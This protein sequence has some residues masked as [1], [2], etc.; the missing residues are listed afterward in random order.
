M[1]QM[2]ESNLK[3]AFAGESQAHMKYLNFAEKARADGLANVARLFEAAALSEQ[4][5]ASRHLSALAG[6][7]TTSE[8][9]AAAGGGE[10]F[11]IE[12]MYP[13]YVAVADSQSEAGAKKTMS[14]A[15]EAE[16]VHQRLFRAAKATVDD[17]KDADIPAIHVCLH[18]G[19]TMEGD[20]PDRCPVCG[21]PKSQFQAF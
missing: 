17:G 12:E 9:L 3:D 11:E 7:G 15:F 16:K 8:N 1:K 18:C 2:T 14:R 4:V 10:S 5:H 19:F 13:A 6:I 21:H 20:A